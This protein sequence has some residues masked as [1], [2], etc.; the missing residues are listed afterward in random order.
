MVG[1]RPPA[2]QL[3]ECLIPENVVGLY[4]QGDE[5]S[6]NFLMRI[7]PGLAGLTA[8]HII[9]NVA[10]PI[11]RELPECNMRSFID[12]SIRGI[13]KGNT[14]GGGR[15]PREPTPSTGSSRACAPQRWTTPSEE[16]STH[17]HT[18]A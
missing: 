9:S 1:T 17:T 4:P 13:P 7:K 2:L 3:E 10:G 15:L 16:P 6:G 11:L 12:R 14:G 5:N 8:S 18:H